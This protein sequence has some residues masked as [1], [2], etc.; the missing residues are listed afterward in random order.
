M[1]TKTPTRKK[2]SAAVKR[3]PR[4]KAEPV[5]VP[6]PPAP[7]VPTVLV[8]PATTLATAWTNV[9][10][11]MS[12]DDSRP[13]LCSMAVEVY[14]AEAV[15]LVAT[16]SYM[17][18]HSFVSDGDEVPITVDP[19]R[20]LVA[21]DFDQHAL[22]LMKW[23]LTPR[24]RKEQR[25]VTLTIGDDDILTV[26]VG[27]ATARLEILTSKGSF[28]GDVGTDPAPVVFPNWRGIVLNEATKPKPT[29]A[30]AFSAALL[31]RVCRAKIGDK[32][33]KFEPCGALG[34]TTFTA[35]SDPPLYGLVMPV[36]T[37]L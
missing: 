27:G 13:V 25:Y 9:A 3:S 23:L 34:P 10:L 6:E 11:A 8:L 22:K 14:G 26:D 5:K 21:Y 20:T 29:E 17:L 24:I 2:A 37:E 18:M 36:R 4:K 1:T 19:L 28:V 7:V 16:D 12:R 30:V 31:A 33:L 35:K 32:A 15:R